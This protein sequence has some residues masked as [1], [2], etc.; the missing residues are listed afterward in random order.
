MF[1]FQRLQALLWRKGIFE[2]SPTLQCYPSPAFSLKFSTGNHSF[3]VSYL[4]KSLGFSQEAALNVS[5]KV[6]FQTS[7]KPDSVVSFFRSLG[8]S[9]SLINDLIR[10]DPALLL[11]DPQKRIL[12]KFEFFLSKGASNSDIAIMMHKSTRFLERSLANHIIPSYELLIRFFQTDEGAVDFIKG[13]PDILYD[14]RAIQSI[15]LLLKNGVSGTSVALIMRRR[16]RSLFCADDLIKVVEEIKCLGDPLSATFGV[17]LLAKMCMSK[18]SWEA[19]VD[20]YKRWG[21]SEE[22]WSEAFRKQPHCMLASKDKIDAVM[23]FWSNIWVEG[24]DH[25]KDRTEREKWKSSLCYPDWVIL[26]AVQNFKCFIRAYLYETNDRLTDIV[27]EHAVA[28]Y[29]CTNSDIYFSTWVVVCDRANCSLWVLLQLRNLAKEPICK[30]DGAFSEVTIP[31]FTYYSNPKLMINSQRLKTLLWLKGILNT[32][33]NSQ[34]SRLLQSY[35]SPTL[36]LSYGAIAS[37]G[38]HS[39]TVS[40]LINNLGFSYE[41]ALKA[42][43]T[44]RFETAQKPDAAVSFFRSHE[45][46]ILTKKLEESII[47]SYGFLGGF[48]NNDKGI[49]DSIKQYPNMLYCTRVLLSINLLLENGVSGTNIALII[50]RRPRVL[51]KPSDLVK[52]VDEIKAM[53]FSPSK[54]Q[55]G[56]ALIAKM[57]VSKSHWEAKA[58]VYRRWGWSEEALLRAFRKQPHF[59]WV[60]QLGWDSLLLAEDPRLFGY[61]L[62]KRTIPRGTVLRYL[63][64]KGLM[65][66][67]S[68]LFFPFGISE[69]QFL[70]RYVN[71]FEKR[72]DQILKL[73]EEHLKNDGMS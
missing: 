31:L 18:S 35:P 25:L 49:I 50:Y 4:I 14:T 68:S 34:Y 51:R 22:A 37:P 56:V 20:V 52:V 53:G 36:S 7:E 5:K 12:P 29:K 28:Y 32:Y 46:E 41:A 66:K 1:N 30:E 10:K 23:S 2:K 26:I 73:Y 65:S 54:T 9:E 45:S 55:F 60:N 38:N 11:C 69:K 33:L 3:T 63:R 64:S 16:P 24:K 67:D 48:F 71:C 17:A 61:S 72:D 15:N 44:I 40:Y 21:W 58:D 19:K 39:F 59:F 27:E 47:P 42:S 6:R 13:Y 43:K 70:E 8:F 57:S 62:N